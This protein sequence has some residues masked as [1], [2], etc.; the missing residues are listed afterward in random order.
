MFSPEQY[1]LPPGQLSTVDRTSPALPDD[2][3]KC[4]GCTR[5]ECQVRSSG[6]RPAC[7][8]AMLLAGCGAPAAAAVVRRQPVWRHARVLRAGPDGLRRLPVALEPGRL[9]A[10]DP[11]GARVRRSGTRAATL[12]QQ[13]CG[14]SNPAVETLHSSNLAAAAL[15]WRTCSRRCS[16]AWRLP[17]LLLPWRATGA[18]AAG[19]GREAER[20][21]GQHAAAQAGGPAAGES[22]SSR[23][24]RRWRSQLWWHAELHAELACQDAAA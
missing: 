14:S 4:I 15:Q 13:P 20:R 16:H 1:Q 11:D 22:R 18:V 6:A 24:Q 12:A 9:P 23:L 10:G 2:A 21:A 5:A 8:G 3:Y 7:C 19:K 17:A